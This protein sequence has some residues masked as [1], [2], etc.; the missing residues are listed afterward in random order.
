MKE[1]LDHPDQS[2]LVNRT[3]RVVPCTCERYA[4]RKWSE[5]AFVT[6]IGRAIQIRDLLTAI[7]RPSNGGRHIGE[8]AMDNTRPGETPLAPRY[9]A[10]RSVA[11]SERLL[12]RA[13]LYRNLAESVCDTTVRQVVLACASELE[14]KARALNG[15]S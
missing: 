11:W 13:Q 3:D 12:A 8:F 14:E 1:L 7:E 4:N 5:R 10:S 2:A 9:G 6:I 15:L